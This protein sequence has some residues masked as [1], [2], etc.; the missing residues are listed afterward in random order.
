MKREIL[1]EKCESHLESPKRFASKYPGE[2]QKIVAGL[3]HA[4]FKCDS[5]GRDLEKEALVYCVSLWADYG[6]IPYFVWEHECVSIL[7][8][9]A[10]DSYL[11]LRSD[12]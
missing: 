7:D 12:M 6:G 2:H 3:A 4:D 9:K 5:C 10:L 11:R 1:C 8:K